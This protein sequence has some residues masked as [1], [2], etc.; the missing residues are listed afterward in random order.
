MILRS[1]L[2]LIMV[3]CASGKADATCRPVADNPKIVIA[4]SVQQALA[5]MQIDRATAF[6]FL[7]RTSIPETQGCWGGVSGNFDGQIISAGAMQWNYG[8]KTLQFLIFSFKRSF[9]TEAAFK[10][11]VRRLMPRYGDLVFSEG[12]A[13]DPLTPSCRSALLAHQHGGRLDPD[14]AAEW[15]ALFESD[16]MVQVQTDRFLSILTSISSDLTRL[17]GNS[18]PTPLRVKWAIDTKVQ[19]GSF[20]TDAKVRFFRSRSSGLDANGRYQQLND[21]VDWYSGLSGSL[22]EE[23]VRYDFR[24]NAKVWKDRIYALYHP[25]LAPEEPEIFELMNLSFIRSR[26]AMGKGGAFQANAFERRVTI[27]LD[28]GTIGG[29]KF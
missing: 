24:Y 2:L 20:P 5:K 15:Q 21:L 13:H 16:A 1:V 27:I 7:K 6:E 11:E 29:R 19:Q 22:W 17:F 4:P 28:R 26:D 23:G 3:L 18:K 9:L 8:Q 14:F 25:R 12:C 10:D